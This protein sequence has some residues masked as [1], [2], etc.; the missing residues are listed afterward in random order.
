MVTKS[1]LQPIHAVQ[2][3]LAT[4]WQSEVYISNNI[5]LGSVRSVRMTDMTLKIKS[6]IRTQPL[7][8]TMHLM[9]L[10][11]PPNPQDALD[12]E[13]NSQDKPGAAHNSLDAIWRQTT[14]SRDMRR[15]PPSLLSD[16]GHPGHN[17]FHSV[18]LLNLLQEGYYCSNKHSEPEPSLPHPSHLSSWDPMAPW[19]IAT[20]GHTLYLCVA[21]VEPNNLPQS[22]LGSAVRLWRNL[23]WSSWSA[24]GPIKTTPTSVSNFM[25]FDTTRMSFILLRSWYSGQESPAIRSRIGAVVVEESLMESWDRQHSIQPC[26]LM[27]KGRRGM[28]LTSLWGWHRAQQ[29]S[30]IRSTIGPAVVEESDIKLC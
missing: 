16:L 19:A 1:P 25:D 5:T 23:T 18:K 3:L 15:V 10:D 22:D 17:T 28:D 8:H 21:G 14:S 2:D 27:N 9:Q 11:A 24:R 4:A 6:R 20:V 7:T 12:V 26:N 30:A 13:P 29:S